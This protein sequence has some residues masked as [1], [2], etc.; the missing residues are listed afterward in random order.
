MR[1]SKKQKSQT[2]TINISF[3]FTFLYRNNLYFV[4]KHIWKNL[5]L[6]CHIYIAVFSRGKVLETPTLIL[7]CTGFVH[8]VRPKI[9]CN[10]LGILK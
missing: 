4:R 7:I 6:Y 2:T 10:R 9:L 8:T 1:K 5:L 3:S